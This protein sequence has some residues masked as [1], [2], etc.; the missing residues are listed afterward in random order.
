MRGRPF[1]EDLAELL[2]EVEELAGD[3]SDVTYDLSAAPEP[4]LTMDMDVGGA[5]V[6]L[7][8]TITT[9]GTAQDITLQ[10]LKI[11]TFHPADEHSEAILLNLLADS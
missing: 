6:R 10:E 1:D 4:F 9:F 3:V 2:R 5:R 8:S 11:E 7:F